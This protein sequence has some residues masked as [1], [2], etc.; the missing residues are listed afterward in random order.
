MRSVGIYRDVIP[1]GDLF[2]LPP[3]SGLPPLVTHPGFQKKSEF[4][5]LKENRRQDK[6]PKYG[7][8]WNQ[9][10]KSGGISFPEVNTVEYEVAV[11][12]EVKQLFNDAYVRGWNIDGH[13]VDL[14]KA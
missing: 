10:K 2:Q 14:E 3:A 1:F 12:D 6:N 4:F 9:I 13:N 7:K 5:V 8:I 11:S